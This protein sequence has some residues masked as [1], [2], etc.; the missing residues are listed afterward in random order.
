LSHS[1]LATV[2]GPLLIVGLGSIGRGLLPLFAQ[3]LDFEPQQGFVID[4][5]DEHRH[6]AEKYGFTFLHVGLTPDNYVQY[7]KEIFGSAGSGLCINVSV[8]ASSVDIMNLVREMGVLYIDTVIEPW[9]GFYTDTS[10]DPATRTNEIM[11]SQVLHEQRRSPGG[12][13]AISCCG[14]NPGMVSWFVKQALINLAADI[15]LPPEDHGFVIWPPRSDDSVAW[16]RLMKILG[17]RGVHVAERDTQYALQRRPLGEFW[18]TWSVDGL[19]SEGLQPAELGWGSH[20][21]W[22]PPNSLPGWNELGTEAPGIFLD[23]PGASTRVRTWCPTLG[24]QIGYLITHN[25]ALSIAD[26]FTSRDEGEYFRPTVHYAY[27]P[28]D[29]ALLSL[30][31][32]FGGS[33]NSSMKQRVLDAEDIDDGF[34]ELGVLLYGQPGG[35]YWFGSHLTIGE[36]RTLAPHQNATGLQVTSAVLAASV[37]ALENP[38]CGIIEAESMD[39]QRCLEIQRPYLGRL[40]GTRTDWTPL[41]GRPTHVYDDLDSSDP[42][43]FR[44]IH[45][46]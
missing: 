34:D 2:R 22:T 35:A 6:L 27:Q 15:G 16:S 11:R 43:Q 21:T 8:D 17:V 7:L 39:H 26:F 14:A 4:P 45:V 30:H 24:A 10:A 23:T 44:N 33:W 32:L 19:I 5:N 37:W 9:P 31:E 36:T 29:D 46:H 13:T 3:H 42:W 1:F 18:N 25:E 12:P 28:C 20:E 38:D 41:S 40:F